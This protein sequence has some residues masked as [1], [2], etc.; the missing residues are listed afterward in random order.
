MSLQM[1]NVDGRLMFDVEY[2]AMSVEQRLTKG[3]PNGVMA[4]K[5]VMSLTASE[6]EAG[7]GFMADVAGDGQQ[8]LVKKVSVLV[9]DVDPQRVA[10]KAD[11]KRF[12]NFVA[13]VKWTLGLVKRKV[14]PT[15]SERLDQAGLSEWMM[16][17]RRVL[18]RDWEALPSETKDKVIAVSV[19]LAKANQPKPTKLSDASLELVEYYKRGEVPPKELVE[20]VEASANRVVKAHTPATK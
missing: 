13:D 11:A 7:K 9:E 5:Y 8:R 18:G 17:K 6:L 3:E 16:G 1:T 15:D 19:E 14:Q 2:A 4:R 12:R 20:R 10:A